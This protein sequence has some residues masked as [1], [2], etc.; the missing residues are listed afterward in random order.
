MIA[1]C[2]LPADA[3]LAR[4]RGSGG[5]TDCYA[6]DLPRRVSHAE[7]VEA[8]YTTALFGLERF[9]LRV[10]LGRASS[11]ADA[12]RLA[13]GESDA[14]AAWSVEARAPDQLLLADFAGRT[15]SWL[16]VAPSG[17]GG[18]RLFFGSA[19]VPRRRSGPRRARMGGSFHA[20]LGFHKLYS[21]LLLGAARG[22]L[23]RRGPA[24][25]AAHGD[26]AR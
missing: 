16:M 13:R 15:R 23:A 20:L 12:V 8:F 4:Y 9:V 1:P 6:T 26:G 5:F 18:T 2:A 19:V 22:R 3:L 17:A 11:D 7:F 25:A 10:F 14:F 21:R 24:P